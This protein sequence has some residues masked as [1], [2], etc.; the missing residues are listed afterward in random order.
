VLRVIDAS[1]RSA[2]IRSENFRLAI[3]SSGME[4][5]SA[6]FELIDQSGSVVLRNGRGW[7]HGAGLCQW[8]SDG[9]AR[10]GKR[11]E[12]IL[13]TYYPHSQLRKIDG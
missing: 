4:I 7:G 10:T 1:G 13:A 8:G 12:E 3:D 5:K 6:D 2:R 9:M 11:A